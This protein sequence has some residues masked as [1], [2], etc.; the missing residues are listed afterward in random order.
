M[1]QIGGADRAFVVSR[2]EQSSSNPDD[3]QDENQIE[4]DLADEN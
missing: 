1:R 4:E 3:Q 2:K